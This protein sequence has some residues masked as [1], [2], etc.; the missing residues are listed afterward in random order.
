MKVLTAIAMATV[1]SGSA[2][3][4]D[5]QHV[6]DSELALGG[7]KLDDNKAQVIERLGQPTRVVATGDFYDPVLEYPGLRISLYENRLVGE[8]ESTNPARC[9]PAGACPGMT[10]QQVKAVYGPAMTARRGDEE[11]LEYYA[12]SGVSCWLQIAAPKGIV[13][14]IAVKCQ[15]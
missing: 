11:F 8:L 3:A 1:L 15:P 13:V 4:E 14:S 5:L 7:I 10:G 6:P 12:A 9:T 2:F